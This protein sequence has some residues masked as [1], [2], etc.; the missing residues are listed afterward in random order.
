VVAGVTY[1]TTRGGLFLDVVSFSASS[2]AAGPAVTVR[3]LRPLLG[4]DVEVH[5][6]SGRW[7]GRLLS[8]VRDSAWFVVDDEDVVLHM[9]DLVS[10]SAA[11]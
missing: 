9:H 5:T 10:V 8:C 11:A 1:V 7:R 2:L 3:S 6:A 4:D